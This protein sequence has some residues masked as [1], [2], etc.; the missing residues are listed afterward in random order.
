LESGEVLEAPL[1]VGCDGK[2]SGL[3]AQ[4]GVRTI[5][6]AYNQKAVVL[7]VEHEHSHEGVA[8]ECF[9]PTGPFAILPLAG[10]SLKPCLVR[11]A[12]GGGR[13]ERYG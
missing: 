12:K 2:F 7:T 13:P 11:K 9:M 6:Y 4:A 8:Y 5:D 10:Q 1:I 3:R